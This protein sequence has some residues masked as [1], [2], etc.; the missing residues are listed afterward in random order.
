MLIATDYFFRL[1]ERHPDA[2]ER[3]SRQPSAYQ[4]AM[5]VFAHSHFLSEEVLQH[6]EWLEELCAGP[7]LHQSCSA[8]Q[9]VDRLEATLPP[10]LPEAV[11]LARFRRRELL[12]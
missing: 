2:F 5:A 10:G 1:Q 8:D 6:P 7:T 4:S 3:L 11:D 12:R 9:Y